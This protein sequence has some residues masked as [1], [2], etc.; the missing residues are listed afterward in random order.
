M[1]RILFS[2]LLTYLAATAVADASSGLTPADRDDLRRYA[3]D[4]WHSLS[5]MAG[6][7]GLPADKLEISRDGSAR[8]SDAPTSPTDIASYLWSILAAERLGLIAA[9]EADH[10]LEQALAALGRLERHRGFFFI[11]YD[12]RTGK[13]ASGEKLGG[14][15][16][17]FLSTVDNGWLAA[18]LLMVRNA[19]PSLR[20]R[21]DG[22]LGPMDFAFFYEPFDAADPTQHPGQLHSGYHVDDGSFTTP[23]GLINTE[24]RI[25]SY[26]AIALGQVPPEHYYRIYRTL[27]EGATQHARPVGEP[28]VYLGVPVFEGHYE[29]R[30]LRVVPSWGGSMFEALMVPLFVPEAAWAPGSWGVNHPLYVRAQIEHGLDVRR[31]GVWGFSPAT[32][33]SGGYRTYGVDALG[34]AAA[35]YFDSDRVAGRSAPN[36]GVVI[37]PHAAFLALAF[38]PR[39]SMDNLRTLVR[40]FPGIYDPLGFRDSVDVSSGLVADRILALDQ[41]MILA[42][43]ANALCDNAMQHLFADGAVERAI[44]PLIAPERFTAGP[45]D[46]GG[47]H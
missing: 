22:L 43:I 29:V 20:A 47:R 44:R 21:A 10:R 45:A 12:P 3:R 5:A 16:P 4:T 37:T 28:R 11:G 18:S 14:R 41:G 24:P 2:L 25:A 27:P 40:L 39:Q 42:A 38:A 35:G 8:P 1:I 7:G 17:H 15:P 6:P 46:A 13:I 31:L 36:P 30:G 19:H 33:P 32:D 26:V 34:T 9:G 23:Y